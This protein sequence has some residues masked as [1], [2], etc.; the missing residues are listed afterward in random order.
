MFCSYLRASLQANDENDQFFE[1]LDTYRNEE[2]F[3]LYCENE[4][5]EIVAVRVCWVSYR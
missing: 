2:D 5:A 1:T 3:A 4:A